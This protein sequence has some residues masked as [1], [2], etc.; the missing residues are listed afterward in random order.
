MAADTKALRACLAAV[1]LAIPAAASPA[2]Q[3]TPS[4]NRIKRIVS[5]VPAVTEM[6]YAVGAGP[7]V[8]AVSSYDTYPPEV[9]KLP[10]VGALLDPNV[11]RILSLRP[12]LVVLFGSQIDLKTQMAR[13]G[14]ATFDYRDEGLA[15]ITAVMRKLGDRLGTRARAEEAA[16]AIERRLDEIRQ[17]VKGRPRPRT[18]LV[19][20]RDRLALRGIYA[21]G[22]VGF[23]HDVLET[24]GGTNIFAN[25]RMKAVQAS[26]EQILALRP[27]VIVEARAATL[28]F[29]IGERAAEMN[30]WRTLASVPAVKNGRV[31]FL[32]DDRLVIP[33]PRIAEGAL[34]LAKALH[35]E[36]FTATEAER[37]TKRERSAG[38]LS[39]APEGTRR[40]AAGA[41]VFTATGA[42]RATKRERSAGRLSEAPEG[43]RRE[44][45]GAERQK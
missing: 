30:V 4:P 10:S 13:A 43:T 42:E 34:A 26:T 3:A 23:L 19:F 45:A 39:E 36:V 25:V 31:D 14:I 8:I 32:F 9:R 35:P 2:H 16:A 38:R 18:L 24:A 28:G 6:L 15:D 11:E 17:K 1:L 27:D 41:E 22:G 12:D 40:E 37:A 7:R 21:S 44:A 20:G 5:L 33:G 29:P